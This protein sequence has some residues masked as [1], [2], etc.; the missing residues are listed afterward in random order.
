MWVLMASLWRCLLHP[1]NHHT[2]QILLLVNSISVVLL[3][4][5]GLVRSVLIARLGKRL[6]KIE[7]MLNVY[8]E[9]NPT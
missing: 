7:E 1:N 2:F 3:G 4:I 5:G 8:S 9:T 6:K